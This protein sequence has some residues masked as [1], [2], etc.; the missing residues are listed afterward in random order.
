MAKGE[1]FRQ[2]SYLAK[3]HKKKRCLGYGPFL[4]LSVWK[5]AL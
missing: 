4:R 2:G 5:K 3:M 1:V